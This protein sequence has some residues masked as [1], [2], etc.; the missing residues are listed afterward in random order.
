MSVKL[1]PITAENWEECVHLEPRP[2]Q[3]H[4]VASNAF[5]LAQAAYVPDCFPLAIYDDEVIVGFAMY[6]HAAG[7]PF[8]FINRLMVDATYQHKGIGRTAMEQLLA[9]L[10]ASPDCQEIGISYHPENSSAR[11]LYLNLGF[12]ETGEMRHGEI[13]AMLPVVREHN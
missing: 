9:Q 8:C 13:V 1:R 12:Q 10:V 6:W 5:S 11:H 3:R 4:F 2:E 7:E